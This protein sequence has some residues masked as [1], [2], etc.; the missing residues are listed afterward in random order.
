MLS[1]PTDTES[2]SGSNGVSQLLLSFN[3]EKAGIYQGNI[4]IYSSDTPNDIR[5]IDISSHT[6]MPVKALTLHFRGPARARLDLLQEIPICNE[7]DTDWSLTANILGVGFSG[8]TALNVPKGTSARYSVQFK[9][10]Q[11][12][13]YE[14]TLVLK[15]TKASEDSFE[16]SLRGEAEEPLAEDH[17]KFSCSQRSRETFLVP[18]HSLRRAAVV[19]PKKGTKDIKKSGANSAFQVFS[20]TTDIPLLVG[21]AEISVPVSG[22][23]YEFQYFSS[24]GGT[25]SG[26][27]TF[28]DV[29]TG[30][31]LWY[32]IEIEV[33]S[34]QADSEIDVS[35]EVRRAVAVEITL[36]NPSNE[37]CV[38]EVSITGPGLIGEEVFRLPPKGENNAQRDVYELIYSPL[39]SGDFKGKISF[40]NPRMGQFWYNLNLTA[41]PAQ[42][43]IMDDVDCMIGSV[44]TVA[45]PVDN[46]LNETIT[47]QA[48][49]LVPGSEGQF[50]VTP[51]KITLGPY[52]HGNF[53]LH[54]RPSSLTEAA[55]AT[56]V[57][58]NPSFGELEYQ[59]T[60]IGLLPGLMPLVNIFS[61]LGEIGSHTIVF[62]NPFAFP[63][64]LDIFLTDATMDQFNQGDEMSHRK[65]LE[66]EQKAFNL[67]LRKATDIV[68]PPK[69][70]Q[71]VMIIFNIYV[72][73]S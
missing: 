7:S 27:I 31:I 21:A 44:A 4:M 66:S 34:P 45:L 40:S 48:M 59:V 19:A 61:P 24:A 38:F 28:V 9:A 12:G 23:D 67:L 33:A 63:L 15:N 62:R 26:C 8:P 18:L 52:E 50:S 47:M 29:E 72:S 73:L 46:P 60:G 71:Q 30:A 51:D 10:L 16:Y 1:D 37:V 13:N 5:V 14:G 69:G 17:L 20:V 32:T 25:V 39:H 43:T 11:T 3:A 42:P 70:I 6:S 22:A 36:D 58:S 53:E 41:T 64:P 54:F 57:L 49:V 35:S 56:I 68:L 55:E 2:T 65:D